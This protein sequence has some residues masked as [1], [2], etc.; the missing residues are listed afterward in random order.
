MKKAGVIH[1]VGSALLALIVIAE[2]QQAKK[3]A[4]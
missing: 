3:V 4:R 1:P 2:A